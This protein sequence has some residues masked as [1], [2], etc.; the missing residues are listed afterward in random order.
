MNRKNLKIVTIFGIPVK[1]N[2]S[3]LLVFVLVA[4]TLAIGYFPHDYPG[5]DKPTYW[6]MG[7]IAALLLFASILIHE[8]SHSYVAIRNNI[9]IRGITLFIFGGAAEM[10]EEPP[11]PKTEF[12][13]AIAGLLASLVLGILFTFA[14]FLG[15]NYGLNQAILGVLKYLAIINFILIAFN[16]IPGFPLDGG[17]ILRA[18][19]WHLKGDLKAATRIASNIGSTFGGILIFLGFLSIFLGNFIGGLWFAFIG[20]FLMSA[21]K[22]SYQQLIARQALEGIPVSQVMSKDVKTVPPSITIEELVNQHFFKCFY[23]GFPVIEGDKLVG[24]ITI[25]DVKKI[26]KEKWAETTVSQIM[27][28]DIGN[29]AIGPE[30]DAIR[31][32]SIMS[33]YKVG[34]IPVLDKGKLVGI[35]ARRDFMQCLEIKV[36]LDKV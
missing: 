11:S 20:F 35:I 3:W 29:L 12:R 36:E 16:T 10:T 13:M 7:I 4:W 2:P 24:M 31:A 32:L 27:K 28:T 17:R 26:P 34:R 5:L 25:Q 23:Y 8:L 14:F 6:L 19:L 33:K 9:P 18:I 21:A 15:R 22:M 1:I 30:D